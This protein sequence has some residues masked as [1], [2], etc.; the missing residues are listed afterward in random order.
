[1]GR[2]KVVEAKLKQNY[3]DKPLA[4]RCRECAHFIF[5]TWPPYIGDPF[6]TLGDFEVEINAICCEFKTK[7]KE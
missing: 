4:R 6:C 2:S 1:M 5:H 7:V 3:Q